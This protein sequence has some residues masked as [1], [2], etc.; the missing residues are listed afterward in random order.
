MSSQGGPWRPLR[1]QN[2][3]PFLIPP[4]TENEL[5]ISGRVGCSP[6]MDDV[7]LPNLDAYCRRIGY[8]GPRTA[9]TETLQ[10]ITSCHAASIP[11]ENLDVLVGR[12]IDLSPRAIEEKIVHRGRGGYCF[13]TNQLLLLALRAIGFSVLTLSARVRWMLS[14]DFIP[15][16]T[17]MFLKLD[18]GGEPWLAD[19]GVGGVSLTGAIRFQDGLE[20]QTSHD[21][22]RVIF[23]TD[24]K[25]WFHQVR[26]DD[27]WWD[28]SEFTG[29]E[30][31]AIDRSIANWWTSTS[32]DSKFKRNLILS[33]SGLDGTRRTLLNREMT[34]RR[35]GIPATKH[36]IESQQELVDVMTQEFLI[37]VEAIPNGLYE[38]VRRF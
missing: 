7:H 26:F 16:R 33:R 25:L 14:R 23:E 8:S 13:E 35:P 4:K 5:G 32:P 31:P 34:I 27:A 20:Q 15:P 2:L 21:R 11:F 18:L 28:V 12:A 38:M 17:H 29:E 22:R 24:R 19:C 9:T 3:G 30:M 37:P 1:F 6:G 10:G 36:S